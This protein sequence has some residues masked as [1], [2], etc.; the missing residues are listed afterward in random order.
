MRQENCNCLELYYASPSCY[1]KTDY[2]GLML[3]LICSQR[4]TKNCILVFCHRLM[5]WMHSEC[6]STDLLHGNF[7]TRLLR[8]APWHYSLTRAWWINQHLF[9]LLKLVMPRLQHVTTLTARR[10]NL[11]RMFVGAELRFLGSGQRCGLWGTSI[12]EICSC[13][14][15]TLWQLFAAQSTRL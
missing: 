5:K 10:Y 13:T 4:H 2:H 12:I 7:N 1:N 15:V 11:D 3:T 8:L 14:Y 9:I 6:V